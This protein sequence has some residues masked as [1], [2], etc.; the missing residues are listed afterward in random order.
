V[1][2]LMDLLRPHLD[3][4]GIVRDRTPA[5]MGIRRHVLLGE[6][7]AYESA[8]PGARARSAAK[9]AGPATLTLASLGPDPA[10]HGDPAVVFG[11][12]DALEPGG[13]AVVLLG[14]DAAALPFQR[15]LD[16][17]VAGSCQVLQVASLDDVGV[18][19][20]VV[21]E[22]V[23]RLAAPRDE[24]GMPVG[25]EPTD[26]AEASALAIRL[27]NEH[28]FERFVGRAPRS[29]AGEPDGPLSDER[30]AAERGRMQR[31]LDEREARIQQLEREAERLKA[32]ASMQVGRT[33]V[34][35]GRSP[36]SAVRLP[37]ALYRIWRRRPR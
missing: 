5:A 4:V 2:R 20:A 17:L 25:E 12:I 15:L 34:D 11:T 26:D 23:E 35:A 30:Y 18:P 14:W 22:H 31:K 32:S 9:S 19:S 37:L 36:R 28:A 13:R 10:V 8:G 16:P 24:L 6:G 33:V 3:G 21:I 1:M 27:A 29:A 7:I